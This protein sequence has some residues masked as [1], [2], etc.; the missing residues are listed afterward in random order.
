MTLADLANEKYVSL[1]TFKRDGTPVA[2]PV[3]VAADGDHLLVATAAESWKVKRLRRDPRVRVA[4]S[5]A[6]GKVRGPAVDGTAAVLDETERVE[7]LLARKYRVMYH[8]IRG[9]NALVR[10]VRR[11][12]AERGVTLEIASR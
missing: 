2:T 7:R 3:W 6:T 9:L 1:T 12:P 11:S 8:A 5:S 10:F 4:A